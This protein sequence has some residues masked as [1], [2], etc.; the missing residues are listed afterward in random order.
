MA[1]VGDVLTDVE[2]IQALD[3]GTIVDTGVFRREKTHSA[4]EWDMVM[5]ADEILGEGGGSV[6]VVFVLKED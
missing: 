2:S 3:E 6:R 4:D 5:Q 1:K